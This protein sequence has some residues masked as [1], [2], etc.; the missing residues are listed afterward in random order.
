MRQDRQ[1]GRA[2]ANAKIQYWTPNKFI[3][4]MPYANE[5]ALEE[6]HKRS[7]DVMLGWEMVKIGKSSIGEKI[8]TFK[9]VD[10]GALLEKPFFHANI[11]PKSAP[12]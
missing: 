8:A 4:K 12:H 3:Y 6:C 7:I 10:T 1:H 9:N 2:A 11:N 5:V